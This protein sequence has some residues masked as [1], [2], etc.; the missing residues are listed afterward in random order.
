MIGDC[1]LQYLR[2]ALVV[3]ALE[4]RGLAVIDQRGRRKQRAEPRGGPKRARIAKRMNRRLAVGGGDIRS[5]V[6]QRD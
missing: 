4:I 2:A 3:S 1:D 5:Q 6:R